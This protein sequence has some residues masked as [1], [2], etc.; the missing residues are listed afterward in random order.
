MSIRF[1]YRQPHLVSG[2]RQIAAPLAWQAQRR[3]IGHNQTGLDLPGDSQ[4]LSVRVTLANDERNVK[5]LQ[6][7]RRF[8][9]ALEHETEVLRPGAEKGLLQAKNDQQRLTGLDGCLLGGEQG[10]IISRTLV[11]V[12]PI[13]DRARTHR[14]MIE[15]ATSVEHGATPDLLANWNHS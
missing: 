10:P 15:G 3:K 12:H 14:S 1:P 7:A 11:S 9:K 13:Q 6:L 2:S 4:D 8:Q 5:I